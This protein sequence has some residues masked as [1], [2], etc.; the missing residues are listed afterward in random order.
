MRSRAIRAEQSVVDRARQEL[1]I[2]TK[3][4]VVAALNKA[5]KSRCEIFREAICRG[6]RQVGGIVQRRNRVYSSIEAGRKFSWRSNEQ[7]LR[8]ETSKLRAHNQLL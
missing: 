1:S 6:T 7:K 2:D 4:T 5:E 8:Y 3:T